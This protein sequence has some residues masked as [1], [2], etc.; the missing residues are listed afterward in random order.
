[1]HTFFINTSDN[2]F[3]EYSILW[4]IEHERKSLVSLDCP[5]T[6][7][8]NN[9]SGY[10]NC[11]KQMRDMIEAYSELDNTFN[12]IVYIDLSMN[13]IYSAIG[14]SAYDSRE[15][16]ACLKAMHS[17]YTHAINN[18]LFAELSKNVRK[19]NSILVMFGEYE[20]KE[21]ENV[22][23]AEPDIKDVY[24]KVASFIGM[25]AKEI[26]E[27]IAGKIVDS[28]ESDKVGIFRSKIADVWGIGLF[29]DI[30]KVYGEE[31]EFWYDSVIVD[32][33]VDRANTDLYERILNVYTS[34]AGRIDKLSCPC[35]CC[36]GDNSSVEA[37]NQ[38]NVI[39]HV[40]KCMENGSIYEETD[41]P[42]SKLKEFY[43]YEADELAALFKAKAYAFSEKIKEI[44][45]F[46]DSYA[47]RNLAPELYEFDYSKF[48]L[49]EFGDRATE[50]VIKEEKKIENE[51]S[52]QSDETEKVTGSYEDL[53][54]MDRIEVVQTE[55]A[56]L[57]S[58]AEYELFDYDATFEV[59][60]PSLKTSSTHFIEFGKTVKKLHN[61][62]LKKLKLHISERLSAY[63]GRSKENKPAIL[64]IGEQR[65]SRKKEKEK[66][67][68]ETVERISQNAYNTV[69]KR[70]ME[71]CAGRAVSVTDISRFCDMYVTRINQ[72]TASLKKKLFV[73]LVCLAGLLVLYVP[74]FI[75]GRRFINFSAL[76]T[77][78][79]FSAFFLP[80][81]FACLSFFIALI[82]QKEKY[83][84][85]YKKLSDISEDII[86]KNKDVATKYDQL[87]SSV[88]PA[89]RWVYEY[90]LDVEHYAGCCR[91]ADRKLSHHKSKLLERIS[92]I[93]NILSD[94]ECTGIECKN[95]ELVEVDIDYNVPFC[96]SKQNIKFYTVVDKNFLTKNQVR[97][98]ETE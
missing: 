11:V 6:T 27:E 70:Y 40:L 79:F 42:E 92:G 88:I 37:L 15:N 41:I 12:V 43:M 49:D 22:S 80:M 62:F 29:P 78:C 20:I 64:S 67:A 34:N 25:P 8:F 24:E 56:S 96:T 77:T 44:D 54:K 59:G 95:T 69:L 82:K 58:S 18:T 50:Y 87:L 7:W 10:K 71:F 14:K 83:I 74:F 90:K 75:I 26:V 85:E 81:L 23:K 36:D 57:F 91:I 65:Y 97:E 72:I 60:A 30:M 16:K 32:K 68:L 45:Q 19:P 53:N 93:N 51:N 55:L 89:L 38:I 94:I 47:K 3:D 17:I 28:N 48:C 13:P 5:F 4:D 52:S 35:V 33:N 76:T 63:A 9:E 39:V 61:D 86:S 98:V 73:A 31:A 84:E 1:M 21:I 46:S 66:K 2:K